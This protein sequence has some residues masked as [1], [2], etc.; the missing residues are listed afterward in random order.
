MTVFLSVTV[1]SQVSPAPTTSSIGQTSLTLSWIAPAS[2]GKPIIG[3]QI[4]VQRGG[5]GSFLSY[6][7]TTGTGAISA[8]LV[9]LLSGVQYSFE[10]AAINS[11]GTGA[12][13]LGST[14]VITFGEICSIRIESYGAACSK[15]TCS[16]YT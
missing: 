7:A 9:G 13:S 4:F 14:P 15:R 11:V 8:V 3:Y 16:S 2:N 12:V 1:P 10:V 6:T 5:T